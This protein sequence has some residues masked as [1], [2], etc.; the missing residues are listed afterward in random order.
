[1]DAIPALGTRSSQ[2]PG[3]S[4]KVQV[5]RM[6]TETKTERI[7][8]ELPEVFIILVFLGVRIMYKNL[9]AENQQ[10]KKKKKE[11]EMG[12]RS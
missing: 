12:T 11:E 4:A 5:I 2:V 7:L 8:H 9:C 1:M 10:W 3:R 6:K